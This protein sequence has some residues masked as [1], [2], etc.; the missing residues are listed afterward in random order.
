M[1]TPSETG[2]GAPQAAAARFMYVG[3]N[4]VGLNLVNHPIFKGEIPKYLDPFFKECRALKSLFIQLDLASGP[5]KSRAAEP[6][7]QIETGKGRMAD[8]VAEVNKW[9]AEHHR[10]EVAREFPLGTAPEVP[11]T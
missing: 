3:P 5:G 11:A 4:I 2:A 8:L 10:L 6:L 1:Q 7:Q 9:Q